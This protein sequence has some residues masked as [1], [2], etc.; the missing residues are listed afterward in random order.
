[1]E[2]SSLLL[3]PPAWTR[4]AACAGQ[5]TAEEDWWHPREDLSPSEKAAQ[6]AVA[7]LV[8]SRCPVRHPCA[9]E[10]LTGSIA[11]GMYGGLTPADRRKIAGRHGYPQ[12]G[13]PRHGTY[14]RYAAYGCRCRDCTEAKRRYMADRRAH[15]LEPRRPRAPK[16]L[17]SPRGKV[18][19]AVRRAEG[20]V[21]ARALYRTTGVKVRDVRAIVAAA[22]AAG[23]LAP[24]LVV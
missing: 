13:A 6:V 14:S 16:A 12:P 18:L 2:N 23:E 21:T 20:P 10:A 3:R 8:C 5:V 17:S 19:R 15:E 11:H 9:L 4:S 22:V 24:G 1:M 7:R